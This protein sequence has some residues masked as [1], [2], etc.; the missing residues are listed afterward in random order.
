MFIG[1]IPPQ[2][3]NQLARTVPFARWGD[4]Y[5]CCSGSFRMD[6][7]IGKAAPEARIHSNDISLYSACIGH[8]AIQQP[9]PIAFQDRLAFIEAHLSGKP[10]LYR[11]AAVFIAQEMSRYSKGNTYS[12]KHFAHY[13]AIFPDLL[14]NAPF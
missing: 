14:G 3:C 12:T 4:L 7:T 5:V 6:Q 13:E 9:L 2:I 11:A 1:A 10:F 8:L